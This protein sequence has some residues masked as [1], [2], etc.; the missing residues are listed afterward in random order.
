[1]KRRALKRVV[2]VTEATTGNLPLTWPGDEG[3]EEGSDHRSTRANGNESKGQAV[4][5]R[6][7]DKAGRRF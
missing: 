2:Q 5:K 6:A 7:A 3:W 1:M 4:E